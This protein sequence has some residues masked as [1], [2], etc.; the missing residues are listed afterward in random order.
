MIKVK[1]G[2]LFITLAPEEEIPVDED[3]YEH[4][5]YIIRSQPRGFEIL[6]YDPYSGW[7]RKPDRWFS[8]GHHAFVFAYEAYT[9]EWNQVDGRL[10]G[11]AQK[12]QRII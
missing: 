9:H 10:G 2:G 6:R 3:L 12:V 1:L 4:Y 11:V 7:K 8:S 5:T